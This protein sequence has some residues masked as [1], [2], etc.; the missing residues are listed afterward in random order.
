MVNQEFF[1]DSPSVF[2][3]Y[4]YDVVSEHEDARKG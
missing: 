1:P 2:V 3:E 4:R